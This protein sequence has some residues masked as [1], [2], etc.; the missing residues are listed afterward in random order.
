MAALTLV[1][2]AVVMQ[3]TPGATRGQWSPRAA[4]TLVGGTVVMQ[5]TPGTIKG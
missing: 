4:L 2:G 3:E 1:G 5:E